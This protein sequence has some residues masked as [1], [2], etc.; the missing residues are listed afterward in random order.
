MDNELFRRLD[1]IETALD[2]IK[3]EV[4]VLSH[5]QKLN[6]KAAVQKHFWDVLKDQ[7]SWQR[8]WSC[9]EEPKIPADIAAAA[10]VS[11]TSVGKMLSRLHDRDVV[12]K[13][14][15]GKNVLYVRA[16][17]TLG[18]GLEALIAKRAKGAQPA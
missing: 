10:K 16:P 18:I 5:L 12:H 15:R 7:M 1:D 17:A 13:I 2:Q 9:L 3:G 14:P 6:A 8:I 4:H 11:P